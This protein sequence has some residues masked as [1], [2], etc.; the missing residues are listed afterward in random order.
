MDFKLKKKEYP[1]IVEKPT[2]VEGTLIES[3]SGRPYIHVGE[4]VTPNHLHLS[5]GGAVEYVVFN[6]NGLREVAEAFNK[7]AD[8][9][10]KENEK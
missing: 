2:I 6:A 1:C 7:L 10:E 3:K 5:W 8:V 9:L 4:A